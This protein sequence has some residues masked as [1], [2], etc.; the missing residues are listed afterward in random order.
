MTHFLICLSLGFG[1]LV[2]VGRAIPERIAFSK[3]HSLKY[4]FFYYKDRF[5]RNELTTGRF[6]IL[7]IDS[8]IAESCRPCRVVKKIGCDEGER[9]STTDF[10]DFYCGDRYL[11]HAK[12]HSKKGTPVEKFDYTGII[13]EGAFFAIGSCPDSFDSRYIGF[14]EKGKVEAI[15]IP[16]F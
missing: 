4:R 16:L 6:V 12:S 7:S 11:G 9:L 14:L 3:T 10:G 13:P 8:A 2:Y 5:A 15:A 1:A